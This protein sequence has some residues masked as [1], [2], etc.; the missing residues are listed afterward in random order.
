M[1]FGGVPL[2]EPGGR[3]PLFTNSL[4]SLVGGSSWSVF[5]LRH[6]YLACTQGEQIRANSN[7]L[8]PLEFRPANSTKV[9]LQRYELGAP[10]VSATT[11]IS[12]YSFSPNFQ[13]QI[14]DSGWSSRWTFLDSSSPVRPF[15]TS[16]LTPLQTRSPAPLVIS[17]SSHMPSIMPRVE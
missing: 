2:E 6:F 8:G 11:P 14:L 1:S 16:H 7:T 4:Q 10:T 17:S 15:Q 5:T 12:I 9:R 3:G 13:P